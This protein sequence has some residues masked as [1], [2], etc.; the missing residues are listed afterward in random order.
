M[1]EQKNTLSTVFYLG[2]MLVYVQIDDTR[3]RSK[4]FIALG[5]FAAALFT[6]TATVTLPVALLL[7][8]W[9]QRGSFSWRRDV[10]PLVPFFASVS[11]QA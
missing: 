7:V 1:T 11:P 8:F 5:L 3:S 4:W 2:A 10:W 9:W 6:K